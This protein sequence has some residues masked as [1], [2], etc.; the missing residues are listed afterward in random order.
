MALTSSVNR[1]A[2]VVEVG[3]P[4]K[5]ETVVVVTAPEELPTDVVELPRL[6]E[7]AIVVVEADSF[8]SLFP[9]PIISSMPRRSEA[10]SRRCIPER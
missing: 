6:L 7:P 2:D 1:P 10:T 9:H 4:L 8:E 5:P 3:A